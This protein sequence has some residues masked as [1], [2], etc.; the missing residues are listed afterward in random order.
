[1]A[2][3]EFILDGH[4]VL[5]DDDDLHIVSRYSW[6]ATSIR[7]KTYIRSGTTRCG[8]KI[9][10]FLHREILGL[11]KGDGLKVDHRNGNGLDNR[12]ENLRIVS[13]RQNN[14]NAAKKRS[15]HGNR[16]RGISTRPYGFA[17]QIRI[18]GKIKCLGTFRTD[19]EAA[20][21]YDL[22]SL[23][24]HGEFGKRNFLPLVS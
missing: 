14:L 17:S 15:K 1:M 16:F 2:V 3:V 24:H 9:H 7:G 11:S 19:V 13:T 23:E 10:F 6:R 22:A 4:K 12:R 20:Y 5:I 18:D 21:A 8:E